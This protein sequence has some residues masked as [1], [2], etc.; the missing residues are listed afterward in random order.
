MALVV[1]GLVV[2]DY[3]DEVLLL[4]GVEVYGDQTGLAVLNQHLWREVVGVHL[5]ELLGIQNLD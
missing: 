2:A 5:G 3:H 4:R 1:H